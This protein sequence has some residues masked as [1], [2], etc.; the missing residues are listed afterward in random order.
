MD[1]QNPKWSYQETFSFRALYFWFHH[2][3]EM[4]LSWIGVP[5][6]YAKQ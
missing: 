4:D 6:I 5:F 2:E 1:M 3:E